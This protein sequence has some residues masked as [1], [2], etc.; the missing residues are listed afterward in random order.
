VYGNN[1]KVPFSEEDP[2]REPISS[3]AAMKRS[4]ELLARA[5]HH[6]YDIHVHC[7]RFFPMYASTGGRKEF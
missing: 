7:L 5:F 1:D 4:G 6:R 2:V 3:Y